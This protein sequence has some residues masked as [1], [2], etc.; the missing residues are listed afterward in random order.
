MK[1]LRH[2]RS[3]AMIVALLG[4]VLALAG[5]GAAANGG[6]LVLGQTNNA[7]SL[8]ALVAPVG[9]GAALK[10]ANTNAAAGSA[11]LQLNVASG[12]APLTVN[13]DAGVATNLN[14]D[15]LDGLN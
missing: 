15:K 14:A 12:H 9:G 3:P 11:A 13:S 7:S 4:L 2:L 10:L 6:N 8:T 5:T 1:L